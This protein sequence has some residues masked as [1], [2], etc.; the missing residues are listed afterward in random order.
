MV[1]S[2]SATV[3]LIIPAF[4]SEKT[5]RQSLR[6]L[7]QQTFR[8]FT[9]TVVDSSPTDKTAQL[10]YDEFPWVRLI[11]APQRLLPHSARN[12]GIENSQSP[13][14]VTTDPDAYAEPTWL[15]QLL[16]AHDQWQGPVSGGVACYGNRWIDRGVHWRKFGGWLPF[17]PERWIDHAPSVNLLIPRRLLDQ[18]GGFRGNLWHGDVLLTQRL[19][20]EG[21]PTRFVP[22]AVVYHHH[23]MTLGELVCERFVRGRELAW[24]R[25]VEGRWSRSR[26]AIWVVLTLLPFRYVRALL[27]DLSWA[28]QAN[29]VGD[30][31]ATFPVSQAGTLAALAGETIGW[32]ETLR[33]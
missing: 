12:L 10:L 2:G 14:V 20:A 32:T 17:G 9:V 27:R 7:E 29:A 6:S 5:I 3:D 28:R 18:V 33:R 8:R 1:G 4:R 19:A 13:I 11:R 23:L 30:F 21:W 15:E 16:K 26:I 25:A 24:L 22:N 31:L